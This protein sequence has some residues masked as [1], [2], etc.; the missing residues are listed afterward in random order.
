MADAKTLLAVTILVV[1]AGSVIYNVKTYLEPNT[2]IELNLAELNANSASSK[3]FKL[4]NITKE[5]TASEEDKKIKPKLNKKKP[6]SSR[7]KRHVVTTKYG[8]L[9][10]LEVNI[11]ANEGFTTKASKGS[12][13][14]AFLGVKYAQPPV[15]QLRFKRSIG[16]KDKWK[17]IRSA[18]KFGPFCLQ[19]F[20]NTSSLPITPLSTESSEDCL[21]LNVWTPTIKTSSNAPLKPVIFFIH[22]K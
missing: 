3:I 13:V 14:Y 4:A 7:K 18:K 5:E 6:S 12:K 19:H 2:K 9:E 22:G 8:K 1:S 21:H 16:L 20:I 10:G 15:N 17:G 11:E